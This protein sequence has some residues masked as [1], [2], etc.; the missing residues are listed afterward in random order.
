MPTPGGVRYLG[1]KYGAGRVR[2]GR[3]PSGWRSRTTS[4]G[5]IS[6]SRLTNHCWRQSG[7]TLRPQ[8]EGLPQTGMSSTSTPSP[9]PR[10]SSLPYFAPSRTP[11]VPR[12]RPNRRRIASVCQAYQNARRSCYLG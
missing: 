11:S 3:N 6:A 8:N 9:T 4:G 7:R 12:T 2:A 5:T 1:A 10:T